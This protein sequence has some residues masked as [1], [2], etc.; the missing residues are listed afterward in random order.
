M[1]GTATGLAGDQTAGQGGVPHHLQTHIGPL[2]GLRGLAAM[3]VVFSHIGAFGLKPLFDTPIGNY[4]VFL[5]FVLSGF[6]MGH[7]YLTKEASS[8]SLKTY[9][10]ARIS[11]IVPIYYIVIIA[12]FLYGRYVDQGFTYAMAPLDLLRCL[13]FIGNVSV[14]WSIGP[15]FQF[16]FLFPLIWMLLSQAPARAVTWGVPTMFVVLTVILYRSEWPGIVVLSKL[17]IFLA[18]ILLGVLRPLLVGKM[19]PRAALIA[20]VLATLV[21]V[22]LLLPQSVV[23]SALY[24][25]TAGDVKHNHYYADFGKLL[26]LSFIVFAFSF[27]TGYARILLENQ[28]AKTVGKY[29]FSI[30][31]L[32]VPILYA[33]Q[34]IGISAALP[35]FIVVPLI[36]ATVLLVAGL[37]FHGVEDPTRIAARAGLMRMFRVSPRPKQDIATQST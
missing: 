37:S 11:R 36:L 16:Y 20:Q 9:F 13:A 12:S 24:P 10:A 6:L 18:G 17:H 32:H 34:H 3:L 30:Y 26:M 31:L 7:L 5:F 33:F 23:G 28:L 4:G 1:S 35:Y 29:S 2:D 27:P 14:F 25:T 8:N 19:S 21:I 15:E 22:A